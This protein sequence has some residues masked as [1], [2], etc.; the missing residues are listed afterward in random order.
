MNFEIAFYWGLI[1][2]SIFA[3]GWFLTVGLTASITA[4]VESKE[5]DN[6]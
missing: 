4:Y 2:F 6:D 1:L 5:G 3:F